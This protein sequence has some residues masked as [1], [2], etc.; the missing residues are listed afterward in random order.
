MPQ[1]LLTIGHS[2]RALEEFGALLRAHGIQHLAD[3]RRFPRSR[4]NPHFSSAAL[5]QWL[6]AQ[7]I[8]YA[9][10]EALGGHREPRPDSPHFGLATGWMRGFADHMETPE[11]VAALDALL[12]IAAGRRTAVMCAEADWRECHRRLLADAVVSRGVPVEHVR[13]A[14]HAEPHSATPG[15]ERIGRRLIYRSVA[16]RL[17]GL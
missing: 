14:S 5:E 16:P 1:A 2:N 10:L 11:F 9:H 3:V 6:A 17:P 8:G 15:L 4:R 13:D 7:R 12:A